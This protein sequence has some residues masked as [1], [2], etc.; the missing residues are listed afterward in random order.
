MASKKCTPEFK[1]LEEY[2]PK[3][4][5]ALTFSPVDITPLANDLCSNE[6][7]SSSTR[8]AVTVES[9][10]PSQRANDLMVAAMGT[11]KQDPS[12]FE[13]LLQKLKDHDLRRIAKKMEGQCGM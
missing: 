2:L 13:D 12:K 6:M 5:D 8:S 9:V 7:I 1:T 4:C 10:A 11:V 3:I